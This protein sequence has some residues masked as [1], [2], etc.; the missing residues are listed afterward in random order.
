MKHVFILIIGISLFSCN[1]FPKSQ[2]LIPD[3]DSKRSGAEKIP[4]NPNDTTFA[5]VRYSEDG[6]LPAGIYLVDDTYANTSRHRAY[7]D[8]STFLIPETAVNAANFISYYAVPGDS[9]VDLEIILS[10]KGKNELKRAM[11]LAS[12][13]KYHGKY[14]AFV[15]ENK[16]ANLLN[17]KNITGNYNIRISGTFTKQEL[18]I[19]VKALSSE[20]NYGKLHPNLVEKFRDPQYY[21]EYIEARRAIKLK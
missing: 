6:Y 5:L 17:E 18:E 12:Q 13:A 15:Y 1:P 20:I 9:G 16:T 21:M 3:S 8:I 4:V 10:Q 7:R 2:D 14:L 19:F 11:Y